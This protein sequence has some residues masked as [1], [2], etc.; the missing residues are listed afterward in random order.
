MVPGAEVIPDACRIT[1]SQATSTSH[2]KLI[3]CFTCRE[4]SNSSIALFA[5]ESELGGRIS[6]LFESFDPEPLGTAS[7]MGTL[8]LASTTGLSPGP[9]LHFDVI[10]GPDVLVDRSIPYEIDHFELAGTGTLAEDGTLTVT[11]PAKALNRAHPLIF[12]VSDFR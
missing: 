7:T 11:G 4:A 2:R 12:S 1:T 8:R 6:K 5:I 10:E 3:G 9:H